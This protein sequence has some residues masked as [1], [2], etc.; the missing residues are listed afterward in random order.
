[1]TARRGLSLC[2]GLFLAVQLLLPLRYYLG[3]SPRFD[4]RFAWRMFSE[5]ALVRCQG[6]FQVG[7]VAVDTGGTFHRIWEVRFQRGAQGHL[8]GQMATY[9]CRRAGGAPIT[10]VRTCRQADGTVLALE[11]GG[12]DLCLDQAPA[13]TGNPTTGAR[14]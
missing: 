2:I 1:M 10:L 9:L 8:L 6:A 7:G 4:E 5:N 11:Q 12:R 13:A 14:R 3:R